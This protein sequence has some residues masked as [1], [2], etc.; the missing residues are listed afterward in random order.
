MFSSALPV[1]HI[2]RFAAP[3]KQFTRNSRASCSPR[4]QFAAQED[5]SN[6]GNLE[7]CIAGD[8]KLND[9][10]FC[11]NGDVTHGSHATFDRYRAKYQGGESQMGTLGFP[12]R[13]LS[14]SA[15]TRRLSLGRWQLTTR[16]EYGTRRYQWE[17]AAK[18][19]GQQMLA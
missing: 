13:K 4:P 7:A 19:K 9:L 6:R 8:W 11:S 18:G 10:A 1:S 16:Q 12:S 3:R 14:P 5:A 17:S 2:T 15:L